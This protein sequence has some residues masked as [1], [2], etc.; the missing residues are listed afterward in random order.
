MDEGAASVV[1][2][3][4]VKIGELVDVGM[5]SVVEVTT[6]LSVLPLSNAPEVVITTANVTPTV[7]RAVNTRAIILACLPFKLR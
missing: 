6:L 1:V 7:T 3:G 2:L 5:G 4:V